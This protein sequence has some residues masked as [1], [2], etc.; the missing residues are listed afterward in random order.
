MIF[1]FGQNAKK[2]FKITSSNFLLNQ[3]TICSKM[4][5]NAVTAIHQPLSC[6][7]ANMNINQS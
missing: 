4:A 1:R 6:S 7:T 3:D 5:P 2:S